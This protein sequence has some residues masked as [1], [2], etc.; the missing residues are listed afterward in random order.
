MSKVSITFRTTCTATVDEEWVFEVE[1][2]WL[3]EVVAE[4]SDEGYSGDELND[5]VFNLCAE[6][7]V[8]ILKSVDNAAVYDESDREVMAM[9]LETVTEKGD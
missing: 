6:G 2:A 3:K 8:Q 9:T 5:A 7:S 4:F 1:D